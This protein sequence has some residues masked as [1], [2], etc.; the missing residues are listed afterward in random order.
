[1]A[2]TSSRFPNFYQIFFLYI[3]PLIG[4]S[5]ILINLFSPNTIL[6]SYTLTPHLP[7]APETLILI[8][9]IASFLAASVFLQIFLLRARPTDVGV[10]KLLM[11]NIL[12]VDA[13]MCASLAWSVAVTQ[14]RG[15][16][17]VR[18]EE[19]STLVITGGVGI[20]RVLFLAGFRFDRMGRVRQE[21]KGKGKEG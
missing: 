15:W 2:S 21:L 10:W 11:A 9:T 16:S 19:I 7:P 4:L 6:S 12:I 20:I 5:G 8:Q 13:G 3:D 17:G 1:M 14:G 18:V